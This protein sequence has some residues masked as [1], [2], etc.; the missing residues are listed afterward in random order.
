MFNQY[1]H[2]FIC[3]LVHWLSYGMSKNA[4]HFLIFVSV[5]PRNPGIVTCYNHTDVET[6]NCAVFALDS[7]ATVLVHMS[8]RGH[9]G[10]K[11]ARAPFPFEINSIPIHCSLLLHLTLS[12]KRTR[13]EPSPTLSPPP[14]PPPSHL[15]LQILTILG[16]NVC[17]GSVGVFN[18]ITV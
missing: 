17:D 1:G 3:D 7:Q 18:V 12:A 4:N 6:I 8:F 11:R 2:S 15:S 13:R 14:P 10:A 16:T 5:N 9:N